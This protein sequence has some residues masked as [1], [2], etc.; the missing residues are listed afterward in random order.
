MGMYFTLSVYLV[1]HGHVLDV[2][3]GG[4]ADVVE[5]AA[6][7]VKISIMPCLYRMVTSEI[8]AHLLSDISNVKDMFRSTTVVN[9]R[10]IFKK[11]LISF[12]RAQHVLSCHL[13]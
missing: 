13:I 5:A 11:G 7:S 8:G 10:C 3:V 1:V 6:A 2:V 4:Q 12:R 9:L